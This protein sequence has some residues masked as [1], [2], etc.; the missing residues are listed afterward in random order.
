MHQ[1]LVMRGVERAR[2]LPNDARR[3]GWI[4]TTIPL[5]ESLQTRASHVP[6]GDEQQPVRFA[7]LVDRDDVGMVDARSHLGFANE[8]GAEPL[9]AGQSGASTFRATRR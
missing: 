5:D 3:P 7:R 9:V 1:S 4:E 2:R 6:H 8:A